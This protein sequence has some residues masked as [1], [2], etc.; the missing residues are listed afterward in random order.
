MTCISA[1]FSGPAG[2]AEDA[3][4]WLEAESWP[5]GMAPYAGVDSPIGWMREIPQDA[6]GVPPVIGRTRALGF[7]NLKDEVPGDGG[8][9]DGDP[10]RETTRPRYL[11]YPWWDLQGDELVRVSVRTRVPV[12]PYP[13]WRYLL[14]NVGGPIDRDLGG[15][16]ASV[17]DRPC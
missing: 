9:V 11:H 3:L 17:R 8:P 5:Q 4:L 1:R 7:T 6:I 10:E 16:P 12:V 14:P 13:G 15:L 2:A